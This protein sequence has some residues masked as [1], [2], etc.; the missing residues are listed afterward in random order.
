M[1]K[2]VELPIPCNKCQKLFDFMK[3]LRGESDMDKPIGDILFEK[4][5]TSELLCEDCR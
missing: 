3:E 5:G 1:D 4:Y 2:G